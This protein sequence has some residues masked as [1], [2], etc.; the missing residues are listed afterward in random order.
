VLVEFEQ[1]LAQAGGHLLDPLLSAP[2]R[3]N[4]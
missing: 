3:G 1:V 4:V 2:G